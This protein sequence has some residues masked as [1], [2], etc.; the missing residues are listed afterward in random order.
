[1]TLIKLPITCVTIPGMNLNRKTSTRGGQM[2]YRT[3]T[4]NPKK[5]GHTRIFQGA[6]VL[7]KGARSHA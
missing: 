2:V 6:S 5:C 1:M 7:T 3:V 4:K